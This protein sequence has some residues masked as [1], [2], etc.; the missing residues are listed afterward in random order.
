MKYY[1]F[2]VN[3]E[4]YSLSSNYMGQLWVYWQYWRGHYGNNPFCTQFS[5]PKIAL[6]LE[7]ISWTDAAV[8]SLGGGSTPGWCVV[9]APGGCL[10]GLGGVCSQG[11]QWCLLPERG[12]CAWSRGWVSAPRGGGVPGLGGCLLLGGGVCSGG[13]LPPGG[14]AWSGG[15]VSQH[16]LRQ[17]PAP[18]GQN[19]W[20][21]LVK[22][23]PW[24]NFV[25]ASKNGTK[26]R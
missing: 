14:C 20:N 23:L 6:R 3:S 2:N 18:C 15:G 11:G 10:R 5:I 7:V 8:C 13:C 19:S 12:V 16:A 21:T 9:S 25:A 22:I 1:L 17:T 4:Q 24:P 26:W